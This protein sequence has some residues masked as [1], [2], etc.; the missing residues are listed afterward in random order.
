MAVT[1]RDVAAKAGVSPVV[2]SRVLHNKALTVGVSES[3][4][5]RVREAAESL[6]YKR[7]VAAI[8]FRT[9]RTMTIGLLHGLG[10]EMP[11]LEGGTKYLAA[12]MDGLLAGAFPRG[13]SV[14]LCPKLLGSNPN[15]AMSDGRFD[16]LILYNVGLTE[17]NSAMLQQ[18]SLPLVL[19]HTRGRDFGCK[20]SSVMCDNAQGI[21]LA[22]QHLAELGHKR[23]AFVQEPWFLSIEMRDRRKAFLAHSRRLGLCVDEEDV[24]DREN[25]DDLFGRDYTGAIAYHDGLAGDLLAE[26]YHRGVR[27]PE[28]F[29]L[30]GFDSTSYCRE[31]RPELT[32]VSQPLQQIGEEAVR[33]LMARIDGEVE[34]PEEVIFPCTLDVRESTGRPRI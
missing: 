2:V 3:T 25:V 7:N 14:L 5:A 13:Y 16:G 20:A 8:S 23:I 9:Q 10:S 19:V 1:L 11:T 15:D 34:E 12:L 33:L 22:V 30:I 17:A 31:L 6:G 32:S 26:A 27:I 24:I 21:E 18:C 4:A 29:S 28:D